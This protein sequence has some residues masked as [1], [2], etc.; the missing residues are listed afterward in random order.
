MVF[1]SFT[2]LNSSHKASPATLRKVSSHSKRQLLRRQHS[3]EKPKKQ[4]SSQNKVTNEDSGILL[5]T[6]DWEEIEPSGGG[7]GLGGDSQMVSVTVK[8]VGL[9]H[10]LILAID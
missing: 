4:R 1:D 5:S 8:W 3:G 6:E 10:S 7:G 2:L 9:V